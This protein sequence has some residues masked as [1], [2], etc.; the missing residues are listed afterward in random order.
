M[1]AATLFGSLALPTLGLGI[2]IIQSN[3]DGWAEMYV[4]TTHDA[5][6]AGKH[7][8]VLSGPADQKSGTGSNDRAP[9]ARKQPCQYDSCPANSGPVGTD[10]ENPRLNWVNSFPVTSMKYG[11]D[12]F[13]P[14]IWGDNKTAELA[15]CGPNLP[16]SGTVGAAVQAVKQGVPALALSGASGT[17]PQKFNET[18]P[19]PRAKLYSE[20]TLVLVNKLVEGG[21]PY[22]PPQTFLNVNFPDMTEQCA[23]V[24]NFKWVM[25][26]VNSGWFSGYD[27]PTCGRNKMPAEFEIGFRRDCFISVSVADA[28]DKTTAAPDKQKFVL[29]KLG[30]FLS[31]LP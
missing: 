1:R 31:C 10:P 30:N 2:R 23:K 29:D 27:Y 13:G 28:N 12:T 26:R 14:Q 4:R 20:L 25:S 5:L 8:A 15:V 6:I 7:D 18:D 21:A 9:E 24:E 22:L 19:S 16:F 11:L 3:D 17:S